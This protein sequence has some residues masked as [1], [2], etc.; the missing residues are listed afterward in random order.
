MPSYTYGRTSGAHVHSNI[1]AGHDQSRAR[2]SVQPVVSV[3]LQIE[4]V[5][6]VRDSGFVIRWLK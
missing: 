4:G 3:D 6:G 5:P 2:E 1:M